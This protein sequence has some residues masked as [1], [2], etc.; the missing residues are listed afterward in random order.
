MDGV[1]FLSLWFIK[2]IKQIEM[3]YIL[4]VVFSQRCSCKHFTSLN[5]LF[6]ECLETCFLTSIAG[7]QLFKLSVSPD[8]L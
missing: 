6:L 7:L 3:R 4:I 5:V 1:Q 8:I 2:H